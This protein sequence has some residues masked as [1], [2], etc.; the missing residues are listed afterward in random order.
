NPIAVMY[1]RPKFTFLK[2]ATLR[3]T[4]PP[5]KLQHTFVHSLAPH[6]EENH[7]ARYCPR[8]EISGLRTLRSHQQTKKTLRPARS[9]PHGAGPQPRSLLSQRPPASR[10]L[11]AVAPRN[12]SWLLPHGDHHYGQHHRD[13]R[14]SNRR[15]RA[16]AFSFRSR[17]HGAKGSGH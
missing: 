17:P 2:A 13:K 11:A 8:S 14:V 4:L 5:T 3:W 16:L 15:W 6:T 1:P 7:A 10:R 9:A 12:G